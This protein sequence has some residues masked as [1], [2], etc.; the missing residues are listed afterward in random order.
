MLDAFP[1]ELLGCLAGIQEAAKLGIAGLKLENNSVEVIT[2]ENNR[3]CKK[4]DN[5]KLLA[6]I[7]LVG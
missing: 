2:P 3:P 6:N 5:I 7:N 4:E 1:V